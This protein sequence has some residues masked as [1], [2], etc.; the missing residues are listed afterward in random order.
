MEPAP[1]FTDCMMALDVSHIRVH[2]VESP[3]KLEKSI[4]IDDITSHKRNYSS[5]TPTEER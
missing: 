2:N 4:K 5:L 1:N 3:A